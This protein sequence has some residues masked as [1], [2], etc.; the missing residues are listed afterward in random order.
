M[1]FGVREKVSPQEN[2]IELSER[3]RGF[4]RF[5]SHNPVGSDGLSIRARAPRYAMSKS[6]G[7]HTLSAQEKPKSFENAQY[8]KLRQMLNKEKQAIIKIL[9]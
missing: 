6:N 9:Q 3:E 8:Y 4:H 2:G 5:P 1:V 7:F